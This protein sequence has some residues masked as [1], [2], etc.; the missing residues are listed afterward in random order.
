[1]PNS[2]ERREGISS[3]IIFYAVPL[4]ISPVERLTQLNFSSCSITTILI[5]FTGKFLNNF[6]LRG[7]SS[8]AVINKMVF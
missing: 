1:M 6:K 7:K 4:I 3:W 2:I 5:N 8:K